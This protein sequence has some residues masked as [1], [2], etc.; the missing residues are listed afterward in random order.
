MKKNLFILCCLGSLC[1][2]LLGCGEKKSLTD[3]AANMTVFCENILSTNTSL[4]SIDPD[5]ESAYTDTLNCLDSMV[6]NFQYLDECE[7]PDEFVS[8]EDLAAEGNAYM[9]EANTLYHQILESADPVDASLL[10]VAQENYSRAIERVD[11]IAS[12]L[13][14]ETPQG[15]NITVTTQETS[16]IDPVTDEEAGGAD[17]DP[18]SE[19]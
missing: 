15:D 16:P 10:E 9:Q 4:Q 17:A 19:E 7:V 13:R 8:V 3:F 6:S 18:S 11:Y 12:L 1:F 14:G 5:S 2:L